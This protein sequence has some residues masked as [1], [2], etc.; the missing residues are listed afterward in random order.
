MLAFY[1]GMRRGELLGLKWEDVDLDNATVRIIRT[2]TR[3]DNGRQLALGEPKTKKSRRNV[4]LTPR[5]VEAPRR[6]WT[7]QAEEKLGAGGLYGD[8]GLVF[9]TE[10]GSLIN[11]SNLR[12]RSFAPLLKRAGL[13][14]SP[15]TISGTLARRYCSRIISTRS[16][17]KSF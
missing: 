4:R 13:P 12:Q 15:F 6:H 1:T 3:T 10:T 16:S 9:A 14:P 11:L 17:S 7:R 2:L 8:Q 5:V